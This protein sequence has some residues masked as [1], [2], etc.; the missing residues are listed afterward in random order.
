MSERHPAEAYGAFAWAFDEALGR[1]WAGSIGPLLEDVL[2][3]CDPS[4]A[5]HLDMACGTG[6][7][8]RGIAD[9]GFDTF[10]VDASI[11][12]L[13]VAGT[14]ICHRIAG[15][16]RQLPIGNTRFGL[17]TCLYDSLN[18]LITRD[19]FEAGLREASRTLSPLGRF[20]FDVTQLTAFEQVWASRTPFVS[21]SRRH[22]VTIRT[23]YSKRTRMARA[24]VRGWAVE[25]GKRK[26]IR[27]ERRQRAWTSEEIE[28]A[29]ART[30]LEIL[31]LIAFDPFWEPGEEPV[32]NPSKVVYVT[33]GRP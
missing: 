12:M 30:G 23:W 26:T 19:D 17:V 15:D 24:E 10:G 14:R 20:I 4:P 27:E 6:L 33:R 7:I 8:S 29:L 28:D 1:P 25:G 22:E 31:E 3:R 18:H 16:I 32:R 9:R 21:S 13:S 2:D 11:P 5:S